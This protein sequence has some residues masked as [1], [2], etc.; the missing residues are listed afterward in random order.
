MTQRNEG[1]ALSMQERSDLL[2][3]RRTNG[4]TYK[5]LETKYGVD[6]RTIQEILKHG[7][8]I[9]GF[10]D[11]LEL[12]RQRLLVAEEY[13]RI[14][15]HLYAWYLQRRSISANVTDDE[16][17]DKAALLKDNMLPNLRGEVSRTWYAD[18]K[19]RHGIHLSGTNEEGH[20]DAAAE[21]ILDFKRIIEMERIGLENVYSMG[22]TG[23]LWKALPTRA[24]R[25]EEMKDRIT[26][27]LCSNALATHKLMPI[28]IYKYRNPR[29]LR[30]DHLLPVI[31][32]SQP[33][34]R[35][36][37]TLFYDWFEN[38]FKPSVRRYQ[39]EKEA[40]GKVILLV[41]NSEA[42]N[43]DLPRDNDF[44]IVYAP[45]VAA[46]VLQPFDH[47]ILEKM[48][49]IFRRKLL[50]R[51][52]RHDEGINRFYTNY[53]LRNCIDIL[54]YSWL[55]VTGGDIKNA[56]Y[57]FVNYDA[58]SV[59][60]AIDLETDWPVMLSAIRGE[61]CTDIHVMQYLLDCETEEKND[62]EVEDT[63]ESQEEAEEEPQDEPQDE[64]RGVMYTQPGNKELRALIEGLACFT[65]TAPLYIKY[66][67][68]S[69]ISYILSREDS[70]E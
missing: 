15:I 39:A 58:T 45:T 7:S 13:E 28:V 30:Q 67:V 38:H 37:K 31:F 65:V 69:L 35:M 34:A 33:N 18:F 5:Q 56:W 17:L 6:L 70:D 11:E 60:Y 21:F 1:T 23:L 64:Q 4:Y 12:K 36:D 44:Q 8:G 55:E 54:S 63:S 47:G 49:R 9:H 52:L 16:L 43:I 41:D 26:V 66:L 2:Y 40:S 57:N 14:D 53:T 48:K 27:G 24:P 19:R 68:Q 32:K 20:R 51:A 50:Q 62:D 3:D 25:E 10:P 61:E 42:H 59:S 22:E 29:A 46:S